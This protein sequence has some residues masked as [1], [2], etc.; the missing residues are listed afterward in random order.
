MAPKPKAQ[1][2]FTTDVTS[3]GRSTSRLFGAGAGSNHA[4]VIS[5]EKRLIDKIFAIVDRDNSGSIDMKELEQMFQIFNVDSS[6]LKGAMN[7]IMSTVDK[8]HDGLVSPGEFYA[9]LSQKFEKGDPK[10][11][12]LAVFTRMNKAKDGLLNVDEFHEVAQTLGENVP[13]TEIKEMLASFH[14]GY[15]KELETYNNKKDANKDAHLSSQTK[16]YKGPAVPLLEAPKK[17]TS[18]TFDDFYAVMQR[19]LLSPDGPQ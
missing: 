3:I 1:S 10:S 11:E 17:P 6:F 14:Q 15:R 18:I 12:V 13:K 5:E 4:S 9:L 2:M 7:R 19:D 8:D 16:E